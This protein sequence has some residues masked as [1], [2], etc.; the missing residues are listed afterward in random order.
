MCSFSI[1][2]ICEIQEKQTDKTKGQKLQCR[3]RKTEK[4]VLAIGTCIF[5][6]EVN[7]IDW[8]D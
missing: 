7:E 3:K 4:Y 8:R 6:K 5:A 2:I 1:K